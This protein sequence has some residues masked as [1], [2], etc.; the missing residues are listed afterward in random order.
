[1]PWVN[2][3]SR[4]LKSAGSGLPL[5]YFHLTRTRPEMSTVR[6]PERQT[7]WRQEYFSAIFVF[8]TAHAHATMSGAALKCW[9]RRQS[10]NL[11]REIGAGM[12]ISVDLLIT[13]EILFHWCGR[14]IAVQISFVTVISILFCLISALR[15][16]G[17]PNESQITGKE[18]EEGKNSG[19]ITLFN[20]YF[21]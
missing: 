17:M 6:F 16:T 10:D 13:F 5:R 3:K 21:V 18:E 19:L 12:T 7:W 4:V 8:T 20:K 11:W 9:C 1:M 14:V 2:S 15:R